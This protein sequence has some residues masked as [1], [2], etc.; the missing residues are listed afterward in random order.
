MQP[1][2]RAKQKFTKR[3]QAEAGL[4][5]ENAKAANVALNADPDAR[6]RRDATWSA[7]IRDR[8]G[9]SHLYDIPGVRERANQAKS[10]AMAR[11]IAAGIPTN[12]WGRYERGWHV[13]PTAGRQWYQSGWERLRMEV[14]DASGAVWTKKHG[15]RIPYTD[16]KGRRRY[17]VPDFRVEID[18]VTFIEEVKGYRGKNVQAKT[19]AAEAW[20][21]EQGWMFVMLDSRG[22]VQ[23]PPGSRIRT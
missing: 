4:L 7:T 17:Y 23:T 15:I 6:G 10:E 5:T 11:R 19:A 16:T 20:C 1:E 14:L 8:Y 22:G 2:V 18:G 13:S 9:V 3:L 12:D 21:A